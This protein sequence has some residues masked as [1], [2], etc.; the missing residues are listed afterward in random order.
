MP[1]QDVTAS[2]SAFTSDPD[3]ERIIPDT[4]Y[5]LRGIPPDQWNFAEGRPNT[6][7]VD[8]D[9][10]STDWTAKRE[11]DD[12]MKRHERKAKGHGLIR[13]KAEFPRSC[14]LAVEYNPNPEYEPDNDAHTLVKGKK[15]KT[16]T[17]EVK[18]CN[19]PESGPIE[20]LEKAKKCD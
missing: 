5:L 10:L 13:F 8:S 11:V 6:G 3:P 2:G 19:K 17:K 18:R 16:F 14:G 12:F 9:D 4:D 20:L 15:G 1:D 7:A